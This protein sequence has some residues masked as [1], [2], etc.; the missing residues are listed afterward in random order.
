MATCLE[1]NGT[2]AFSYPCKKCSGTGVFTN[3]TT[4]KQVG[5][6]RL[7]GG[8]GRFFPI[9]KA[10]KNRPLKTFHFPYVVHTLANGEQI[11][12]Y[13]CRRCRGSGELRTSADFKT[14][15]KAG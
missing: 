9:F 14:R 12:A 7:C 15:R 2:G 3:A 11:L 5:A 8:S 6:C 10:D 1:C 4:G 13:R